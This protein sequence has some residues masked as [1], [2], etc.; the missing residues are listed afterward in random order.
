METPTVRDGAAAWRMARDSQVLDV[1]SAYSYLLWFRDF[2]RTSVVAS[3]P[4]GVPVGFVTG[5]RRPEQ[6]DTLVVWQIAV[7]RG[8]RGRGIASAMLDHLTARL[9]A[10]GVLRWLET[11]V[12]PDN[13]ASRRLFRAFAERHAAAL[14][15]EELFP[16]EL[17]PDTHEAEDLY[18]IGPLR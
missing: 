2:A 17:F 7:D 5:F 14:E 3:E 10:R 16:A 18:R 15:R 1:N 4:D 8:Q 12:S 11:T 9:R 6:H 13:A